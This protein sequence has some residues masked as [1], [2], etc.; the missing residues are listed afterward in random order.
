M[1]V[2]D[3]ITKAATAGNSVRLTIESD[4]QNDVQAILENHIKW[5][6]YNN[7]PTRGNKVDAG[8]VVVLDAKTGAVL[9]M[10][11][12]P[13]YDINNYIDLINNPKDP[14]PTYNRCI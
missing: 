5:L 9:A 13:N 2:S 1:V 11:N 8:G 4:F 14:N 12:Y 6:H 10:A 7:D 3:E